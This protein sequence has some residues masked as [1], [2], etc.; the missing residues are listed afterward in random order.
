MISE[1]MKQALSSANNLQKDYEVQRIREGVRKAIPHADD[2]IAIL[3]KAVAHLFELIATL[4]EGEL[5][6]AEFAE[7]NAFVEAIKVSAKEELK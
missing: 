6:N 2:E 1:K 7:Y 4:H 3:R 5:D